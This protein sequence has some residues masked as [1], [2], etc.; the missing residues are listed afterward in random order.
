MYHAKLCITPDS[1]LPAL[2]IALTQ[3]E[4]PGTLTDQPP[5]PH[6]KL[7]GQDCSLSCIAWV[8][9]ALQTIAHLHGSFQQSFEHAL[10]GQRCRPCQTQA[11]GGYRTGS[12]SCP[13]PNKYR[14]TS[15]LSPATHPI[16]PSKANLFFHVLQCISCHCNVYPL[17]QGNPKSCLGAQRF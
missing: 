15:T 16:H 10:L 13:G 4:E 11:S 5:R 9:C 8:D 3:T 17:G 6:D 1:A 2:A 12:F 14:Q 7:V